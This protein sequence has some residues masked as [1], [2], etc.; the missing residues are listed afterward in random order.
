MCEGEAKAPGTICTVFLTQD[1]L[2]VNDLISGFCITFYPM[3]PLLY[4]L[5][6]LLLDGHSS[7]YN[8]CE[9]CVG[10]VL[11]HWNMSFK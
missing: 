3:L 2:Q 1:G 7:H 11:M 9:E 5:L 6:L 10:L 8:D 4:R